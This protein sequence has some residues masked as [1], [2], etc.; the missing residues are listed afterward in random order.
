MNKIPQKLDQQELDAYGAL[1]ESGDLLQQLVDRQLRRDAGISRAQFEILARLTVTPDGVRMS[2][3]ADRSVLSKSGMTYRVA[4]LEKMGLLERIG[5]PDDE[6]GIIARATPKGIALIAKVIPGHIEIVRE[7]FL[8]VLTRDDLDILTPILQR[9][10]Q[11]LRDPERRARQAD[12]E[13]G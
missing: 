8:R 1:I 2:E 6:R 7:A 5:D 11:R 3:L 13:L 12:D 4:Q 10:A 9:V